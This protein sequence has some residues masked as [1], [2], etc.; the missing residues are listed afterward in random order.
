MQGRVKVNVRDMLWFLIIK[1]FFV[2]VHSVLL[3]EDTYTMT[4]LVFVCKIEKNT[5]TMSLSCTDCNRVYTSRESLHRHIRAIHRG[6]LHACPHCDYKANQKSNL[7][8][9][10]RRFHDGGDIKTVSKDSIRI[11]S[12]RQN[13]HAENYSKR[14][15]NLHKKQTQKYRKSLK[16]AIKISNIKIKKEAVE[17]GEIQEKGDTNERLN[18]GKCERTFASASSL[19]RHNQAVHLGVTYNCNMCDYKATQ[20]S[21]LKAHIDVIH[22]KKRLQCKLCPFGTD[23]KNRFS[24]HMEKSH[25]GSREEPDMVSEDGEGPATKVKTPKATRSTTVSE[26]IS[27]STDG[28]TARDDIQIVDF[29]CDLCLFETDE[30]NALINHGECAYQ[31]FGFGTL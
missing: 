23:R 11:Q 15:N 25:A 17:S 12:H 9:H 4:V 3:R 7:Y 31:S 8:R 29:Y 27:G 21:N 20:Q 1:V 28:K 10:I 6:V 18:C 26:Q 13:E 2:S 24:Q 5:E 30:E 19:Y 14:H 16:R 22:F